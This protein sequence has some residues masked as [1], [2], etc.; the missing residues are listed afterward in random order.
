VDLSVYNSGNNHLTYYLY[1]KPGQA[2]ECPNTGTLPVAMTATLSEHGG[3]LV[4][5]FTLPNSVRHPIAGT[6]SAPIFATLTTK[7]ATRTVKGKKVGALETTSCPANHVRQLAIKFTLE[8]GSSRIT[9]RN[10]A[11]S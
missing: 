4:Q 6:D 5:K 7:N 1:L 8:N 2:G 11:C 10:T 9:T 3:N